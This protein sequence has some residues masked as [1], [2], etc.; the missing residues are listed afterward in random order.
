MVDG[1]VCNS[2]TGTSSTMRCYICKLTIKD[3]NN[4][5]KVLKH[6]V[7]Q[8]TLG[9][10]LFTLHAWI[11]FYEC[12]LH[13]SYKLTIKKWQA[14]NESEK[15][16]ILNRKKDIQE[17]FKQQL[18]I[19]VDK[20]KPGYGNSNDGDSARRFF[21]NSEISAAITEVDKT[22]IQRFNLVLQTIS[23]E[24]AVNIENFQN[25][26]IETAKLYLNLYPW[27]NMPVCVHKILIHGS[28]VVK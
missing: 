17:K 22:L 3:F 2:A 12:L 11:R 28:I 16:I 8:S 20:P 15:M 26:C 5:D 13:L 14:R 23:C 9:F 25:Y 27:Y 1:R 18:G 19:I 7:D 6:E 10:G 4:L 24:F 21:Q